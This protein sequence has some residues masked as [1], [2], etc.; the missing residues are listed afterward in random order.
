MNCDSGN[1]TCSW[2]ETFDA[3]V[4]KGREDAEE[5]ERAYERGMMADHR[6]TATAKALLRRVL[7]QAETEVDAEPFHAILTDIRKLLEVSP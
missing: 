2:A 5:R 3:G 6:K 4:K 7:V 1:P